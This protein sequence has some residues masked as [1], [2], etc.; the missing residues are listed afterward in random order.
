VNS[1][2][3]APEGWDVKLLES[4]GEGWKG[5][6]TTIKQANEDFMIGIAG[7]LVS[8]T[9][10]TGFSSE[11]LYSSVRFDLIQETAIP[12]AHAISTQVL[13]WY[14]QLN[15]P[16]LLD[17]SPGFKFDVKRPTDL[18]PEAAIYTAL[19]AGLAALQEAASRFGLDISVQSIFAKF[20]IDTKLKPQGQVP[21]TRL[22]LAPTDV[23]KVVTVDEAR[24]SQG[25]PRIGDE[26]GDLTIFELVQALSKQPDEMVALSEDA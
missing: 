12:M 21:A 19:G 2:F 20:G 23:A 14:T 6:D 8:V 4:N 17:R 24:V 3:S 10:G 9:G 5:F 11:D 15:F 18:N 13:P 16:D 26:R 22:T 7:Q 1:I 25:L